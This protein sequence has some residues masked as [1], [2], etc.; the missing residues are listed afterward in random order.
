LTLNF[1]NSRSIKPI[2]NIN[3]ADYSSSILAL[4]RF[5][6]RNPISILLFVHTVKKKQRKNIMATKWHTKLSIWAKQIVRNRIWKVYAGGKP[7]FLK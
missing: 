3:N 5:V 7:A 4:S 2:I 6:R 1:G